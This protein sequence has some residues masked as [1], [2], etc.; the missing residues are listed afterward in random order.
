VL[1]AIRNG[2]LQLLVGLVVELLFLGQIGC[3]VFKFTVLDRLEGV[4]RITGDLTLGLVGIQILECLCILDRLS[5]VLLVFG[6][7]SDTPP[8][9]VTSLGAL[10]GL[11]AGS[12]GRGR[13]S[14][15]VFSWAVVEL[16]SSSAV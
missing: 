15:V 7:W 6:S 13:G 2:R 16:A 12:G 1:L 10:V 4:R 11:V 9:R 8:A 14:A 5:Q 3:K